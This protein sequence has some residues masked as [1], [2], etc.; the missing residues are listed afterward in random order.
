MKKSF[1]TLVGIL[2]SG[3]TSALANSDLSDASLDSQYRAIAEAKSIGLAEAKKRSAIEDQVLNFGARVDG[4]VGLTGISI[5][6]DSSKFEIH[7]RVSQSAL[8]KVLSAIKAS[9]GD[10]APYVVLDVS[11]RPLESL[12]TIKN[13][14]LQQA[15]ASGLYVAAGVDPASDRVIVQTHD[16]AILKRMTQGM[17]GYQALIF[18]QTDD[19][20]RPVEVSGGEKITTD[21]GNC[22]TGFTVTES[23]GGQ[24]AI[25]TGGHCVVSATSYGTSGY[26]GG[27]AFTPN[28]PTLYVRSYNWGGANDFSYADSGS[29]TYYNRVYN[30]T[31]YTSITSAYKAIPAN[32]ATLCKYGVAT[33]YTCQAVRNNNWTATDP[34]TGKLIGPLVEL[35]AANKNIAQCGDSGGPVYKGNVAYGITSRGDYTGSCKGG[36]GLLFAPIKGISSLGLTVKTS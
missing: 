23:D 29:E 22:T 20:P 21:I 33:G 16:T 5:V 6:S 11:S 7:M 1:M 35:Y 19:L 12:E 10:I 34:G 4:L 9:G 28:A 14:V 31:G 15:L 27:Y 26:A 24:S 17:A 36:P 30:G 25:L 32:G 13:A 3:S 8:P 18:E 2:L